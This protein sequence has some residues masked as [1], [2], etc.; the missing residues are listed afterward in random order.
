MKNFNKH[1]CDKCRNGVLSG[2]WPPPKRIG[3]NVD[4]PT[5]LHRCELCGAYWDFD[6]RIVTPINE[7][8]AKKM[9]PG[10]FKGTIGV[11]S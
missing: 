5:F 1:G 6:I 9:Y 2:L 3:V 4:G 8:E 10:V 7:D 11:S